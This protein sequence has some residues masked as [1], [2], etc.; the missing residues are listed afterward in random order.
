MNISPLIQSE[1]HARGVATVI[2]ALGGA[3]TQQAAEL[4]GLAAAFTKSE[5]SPDSLMASAMSSTR[6]TGRRTRR[7]P[8]PEPFKVYA[9]LGV[10]MGMVNSQ[11]LASLSARADV[12]HVMAAPVLS[13][14]R[15]YGGAALTS[16]TR[17]I[18]WGI[19][20]LRVPRLW[21]EGLT[22]QGVRV[23][24]LDTGYDADHPCLRTALDAFAYFDD[25]GDIQPQNPFDDDGHGT[26]TAATIGG[27]PVRGK[28]VG[29]AP[30]AMLLSGKVIEGGN[31][32]ARV[33][34]GMDWAVGSGARIL[35]M[36]LGFRGHIDDFL[37]LTQI[38][39]EKGVLPVF[40]VGNE[41]PGYT[42]SPGNYD[43]SL[44][45]GAH[46]DR[47]RIAG[48]SSSQKIAVPGGGFRT[49]P[50]MV[51]PG[52]AVESAKVGGGYE[53]LDGTSMATPHVSGLAALLLQAKPDAT[54]DQL[55]QA[56][57]ASCKRT[58]GTLQDRAGRGW[59]DAVAA[60][61]HLTGTRLSKT[62]RT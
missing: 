30:D 33:L 50:D 14:I 17:K 41:G 10:A 43:E 37:R 6:S 35:N 22:G 1:L 36:S 46:D 19:E 45:V 16:L 21:A 23:A 24:H 58:A 51:A 8:P 26:H 59:P 20:A 27:R 53:S 55:E 62:S 47:H 2:V 60:L 31:A 48:F 39:R 38:L 15:P 4:S 18:T 57:L 34:G 61:R 9:N 52:V 28:H 12:R 25:F 32:V 29:V 49:V 42:R 56:I 40:A 13:L 5:A 11:G 7:Q 3:A 54:V 44:S